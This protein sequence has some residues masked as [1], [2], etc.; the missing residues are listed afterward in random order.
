VDAR[1]CRRQQSLH[2]AQLGV[3][4]LQ[5]GGAA[6]EHLETVVVADRHFVCEPAQVPGQRGHTLGQ[7]VASA[8][9]LGNGSA[10]RS[11]LMRE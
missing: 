11:E 6:S 10:L 4:L 8:A 7:L 3:G 9:Q 2:L 1:V 5:L